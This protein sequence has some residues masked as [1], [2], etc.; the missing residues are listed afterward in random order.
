MLPFDILLNIQISEDLISPAHFSYM[1]V[2]FQI[3][4]MRLSIQL[5]CQ[6]DYEY[7]IDKTDTWYFTES[8]AVTRDICS[9]K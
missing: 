5:T 3:L 9:R 7:T 4:S 6:Y 8:Q 2:A 1:F